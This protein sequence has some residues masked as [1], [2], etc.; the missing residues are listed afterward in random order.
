M[1]TW[2]NE[3][4]ELKHLKL[5]FGTLF[6]F[7]VSS[8]QPFSVQCFFL[9][10]KFIF[11]VNLQE[12]H[13][14]HR[15]VAHHSIN[16]CVAHRIYG[17]H[18]FLAPPIKPQPFHGKT[19]TVSWHWTDIEKRQHKKSCTV[20]GWHK[21][22][23]KRLFIIIEGLMQ[24]LMTPCSRRESVTVRLPITTAVI[25]STM[26][27]NTLDNTGYEHTVYLQT[28]TTSRFHRDQ[29]GIR[30]DTHRRHMVTEE[31]SL[32]RVA[33]VVRGWTVTECVLCGGSLTSL[34]RTQRD[35]PIESQ[36]GPFNSRAVRRAHAKGVRYKGCV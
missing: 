11:N 35:D 9:P 26:K 31:P 8:C 34:G 10:C 33:G 19:E 29:Y 1:K 17:K 7:F 24:G 14:L 36:E 23:K 5:T 3:T 32:R 6:P 12:I 20:K 27:T 22:T 16:V 25:H 21:E 4:L 30:E 28:N 13:Y 18:V 2:K 15:C